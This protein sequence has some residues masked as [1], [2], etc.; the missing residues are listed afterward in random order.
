MLSRISG[1]R[2]SL[3][4]ECHAEYMYE[5]DRRPESMEL[6]REACGRWYEKPNKRKKKRA[7]QR[8]YARKLK[9]NEQEKI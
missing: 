8:K 4:R 5:Y 7:Y 6:R 1:K 3:C 9:K 2:G